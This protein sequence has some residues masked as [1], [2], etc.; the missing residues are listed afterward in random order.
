[1]KIVL[2][3]TGSIAAHKAADL[4][5]LLAKAG[6]DVRAVLTADAQKPPRAAGPC[7]LVFLDPPYDEPIAA[8]ALAALAKA[9]W[10][11]ADALVVVEL[12]A[13]AGFVPPGGFALVEERGYG[14]AR[15]LFLRYGVA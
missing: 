15:I 8:P 12:A 7:E 4:A 1:M 3:V 2:G 5:S 9:G 10:V 6:Y 11:A 13:R 14:A